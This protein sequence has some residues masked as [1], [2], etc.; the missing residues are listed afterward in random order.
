M[1]RLNIQPSVKSITYDST[2]NRHVIQVEFTATSTVYAGQDQLVLTAALYS[3]NTEITS[4]FRTLNS[5]SYTS[6]NLL[7]DITLYYNCSDNY[8]P[9]DEL[10]LRFYAR[11]IPYSETPEFT[12]NVTTTTQ[13]FSL[14]EDSGFCYPPS[15]YDGKTDNISIADAVVDDDNNLQII[16]HHPN[17]GK[18][19]A[20]SY[21]YIELTQDGNHWYDIQITVSESD[22]SSDYFTYSIPYSSISDKPTSQKVDIYISWSLYAYERYNA[23]HSSYASEV[24]VHSDNYMNSVNYNIG[25][26]YVKT[27]NSDTSTYEYKKGVLYVKSD[28]RY[29]VAQEF[30]QVKT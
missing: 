6:G 19:L 29:V 21:I 15:E 5:V 30:K 25:T 2:T 20:S 14:A 17:A 27:Y 13:P 8:Y 9:H 10:E 3:S 1:A 22:F 28:N 7:E 12:A 4:D 24:L 11:V 16:F 23:R 18:G 26:V